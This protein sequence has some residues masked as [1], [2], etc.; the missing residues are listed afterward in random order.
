MILRKLILC[1]ALAA[2][3]WTPAAAA[4]A[5]AGP[6]VSLGDGVVSIETGQTAPF[7]IKI[8]DAVSTSHADAT[9]DARFVTIATG[10]RL[11]L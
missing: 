8:T 7:P 11:T 1:A 6:A 10:S 3:F 5:T 2:C 4:S 9:S